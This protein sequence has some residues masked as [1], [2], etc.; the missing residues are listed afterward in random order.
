MS[1]TLDTHGA[2][3]NTAVSYFLQLGT[4]HHLPFG[5]YVVACNCF[6]FSFFTSLLVV[7]DTPVT[8]IPLVYSSER[9]TP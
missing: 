2:D 3:D 7:L 4:W 1:S 8:W 5:I 9:D 6:F